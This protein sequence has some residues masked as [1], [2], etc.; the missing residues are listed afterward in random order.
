[1]HA[2]LTPTKETPVL[3]GHRVT[4]IQPTGVSADVLAV[5]YRSVEGDPSIEPPRSVIHIVHVHTLAQPRSV[6]TCFGDVTTVTACPTPR[7]RNLVVAGT[8]DGV[9]YVWDVAS[10][11]GSSP[12]A[13]SYGVVGLG[14]GPAFASPDSDDDGLD[15]DHDEVV[16]SAGHQARVVAIQVL[17][18]DEVVSVDED[19]W[20]CTWMWVPLAPAAAA[21][22]QTDVTRGLIP[23]TKSRACPVTSRA[24][25]RTSVPTVLT[26]AIPDPWAASPGPRPG[27]SRR[28]GLRPWFPGPILGRPCQAPGRQL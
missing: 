16:A 13:A 11:N 18:S 8:D 10:R 20:V 2:G 19:G 26:A 6:L 3:S 9:L 1:M 7:H 25:S 12:I 22:A 5:V 28:V 15:H 4:L 17:E 14:A 23:G 21:A 24:D 27:N